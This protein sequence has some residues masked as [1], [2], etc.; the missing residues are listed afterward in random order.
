MSKFVHLNLH[1]EYSMVDSVVRIPKLMEQVCQ[2]GMPAVAITDFSN[3]FALVKFYRAA[4]KAGVKPIIGADLVI[5]D[6]GN[7]SRLLLLC[8]NREGYLNLSGLI[9]RAYLEGQQHG[10]PAIQKQ[11]LEGHSAGLIAL[12][13]AGRGD[14]GKALLVGDKELAAQHLE[15]WQ[16]LFGEHYF[17]E[18]QRVGRDQDNSLVAASVALAGATNTPVVA[19]NDVRFLEQ[20]H[21]EGHEARVCIHQGRVLHDSRRPREYTDQQ[22]LRSPQEMAELFSDLPEALENTLEIARSCS[23]PVT[24]GENFLP[25]FP[26]ENGESEEQHLKDLASGQLDE[27]LARPNLPDIP[28]AEYHQRLQLELDVII[29]M[30]FPGY[31]LIVADFIQWARDNGV[32]VG[33]G[34]GSGAGSLVAFVLGITRLDP[35]Q[36]SLLFERFLN[37][38]RVSLPD[39]DID[40]CMDGRDRV[41][42]YVARRYGR[43]RVSQIITYGTMAAKAVIRDAG[44]VL[45]HPYGFVD[46]LAKLIPMDLGITLDKALEQEEQLSSRYED[47]EEVRTL[48]DLARF[49]EGLVRNAGKHAGGVVI[50]PQSLT[51]FTPL[52]SEP[53]G[54]SQVTQLD[55]DDVESIGL[56][57]F[58]FLGLRTLTIIEQA[59]TTIRDSKPEQK[60]LDIEQIPLDDDDVFTMLKSGDTTAVFQLES[61]GMQDLIKRLKPDSFDDIVALV[62]L[63]RP[64][65][66]QSGMV[67]DFINRKHGL[68]AVDYL[69]PSLEP[70][71]KP[72]YGVILYQEQVMQIAQVLSGFSL[73]GADL[74]R[75]AM[76][77]KKAE[78]MAKQRI[79]FVSGAASSGVS[80]ARAGDIFDLIEKFA[81][82]G[83][84][85][86]HSAAYALVSYQTA[87]LKHHFPAAF[88][89]AVLSADMDNTDKIVTLVEDC[90]RLK[91]E[92][93]QPDVN[94]SEFKFSVDND[95]TIRYGLGAIKG[96]GEGAV[97][98]VIEERQQNGVYADL[99]EFCRR[100]D[101]RKLNRRT[102]EGLIRSGALTSLSDNR[103][104]LLASLTMALDSAEQGARNQESGQ[105]DLF[106]E[107]VSDQLPADL[108]VVQP[109]SK[110]ELLQAER[111]SLGLYL[112]GHPIETY[113][114]ELSQFVPKRLCDVGK[115]SGKR[116]RI[117]GLVTEVRTLSRG[118]KTTFVTLDDRTARIDVTVYERLL[119]KCRDLLIKDKVVIIE[120]NVEE[121]DYNGGHKIIAEDALD[122]D[123]AREHYAISL[124]VNLVANSGDALPINELAK[125]IE[126]FKGGRC[127]LRFSY[128]SG[129]G[130]TNLRVADE[131]LL[132]PTE[133]LLTRLNGCTGV[134]SCQVEYR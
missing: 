8:R 30:G 109:W 62:A 78:E 6:Q 100:V 130:K 48:I 67:D 36:Y 116:T 91:L 61:R 121:D 97:E 124:C 125:V 42:D 33:P 126:P 105:S 71:L 32:P 106:G 2:Q 12:S 43:D 107:I 50:A 128:R 3:L 46:T 25:T 111:T 79:D 84:N 29:G 82:Y 10:D 88:M 64:G 92:V 19:T 63:F 127:Q 77:K 1:T 21:F 113:E 83:F 103:A 28:V 76:G 35:L 95:H 49:L 119:D 34:R 75:R 51:E 14:V 41:I 118:R 40:F 5:R 80:E 52:Y 22:Y 56:V 108:I 115:S 11:W 72:T 129:I 99:F 20:E 86:S 54:Q 132:R 23:L 104:S 18:L 89:A 65:P 133:E 16:Q 112:T 70:V 26:L 4:L 17:L 45:A 69:E 60:E 55:K 53:N 101:L 94:Y 15:F 24:L 90:R 96:V 102:L 131:W 27:Y 9:S 110:R 114:Q 66:L 87:W 117:A 123:H 57:K 85:K 39:F 31:F 44:R 81:G 59:V 73:G 122:I 47:E 98:A 68:A 134:E 13:G 58:D 7:E 120:G 38:E 37:P 93:L 74:L